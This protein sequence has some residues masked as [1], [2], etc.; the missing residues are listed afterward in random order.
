MNTAPSEINLYRLFVLDQDCKKR[1]DQAYAEDPYYLTSELILPSSIQGFVLCRQEDKTPV[2]GDTENTINSRAIISPRY[3]WSKVTN[4]AVRMF[5][6]RDQAAEQPQIPPLL[7]LNQPFRLS[8]G[9]VPD[10]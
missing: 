8:N 10:G 7:P 6:I 5:H 4:V 2:I 3:L 9:L 1:L